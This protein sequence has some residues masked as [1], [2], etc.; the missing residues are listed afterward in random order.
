L[1]HVKY[2]V[3]LQNNLSELFGTSVVLRQGDA[4][5]CILF[6]TP[7][8]KV[9]R[10]LVIETKGIIHNKTIQILAYADHIVLVERT[11]GVLKEAFTDLSKAAKEI[12]L[13]NQ[14]AKIL[15]TYKKVKVT[16]HGG[17]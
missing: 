9:V 3:K 12:G 7:L 4:L 2:I 1:E 8:E 5:S 13:N 10:D 16:D 11:A 17:P 15:N 14:S 6:S